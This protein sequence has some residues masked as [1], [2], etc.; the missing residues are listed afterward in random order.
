MGSTLL[1]DWL[2][3][4]TNDVPERDRFDVWRDAFGSVHDVFVD[5][6]SR[7][8]FRA[9]C[10]CLAVRETVFGVY[11]APA[12]R[13][14]RAPEHLA[15][16]DIDHLAVRIA[17]GGDIRGTQRGTEYH[18]T[19]G[20]I[21][22]G[23]LAYGYEEAHSAGG[24]AAAFLPRSSLPRFVDEG[25]PRMVHGVRGALLRDILLSFANS[26]S[27]AT[28]DDLLLFEDVL[29]RV[30]E[31]ILLDKEGALATDDLRLKRIDDILRSEMGSPRLNAASICERAGLSR[32]TLYR[33]FKD[34]GG[35][36]AYLAG[37]RLDAIRRDLQAPALSTYPISRIAENRG[38]HNVSAFNRAFQRRFGCTPTDVR[39]GSGRRQASAFARPA[40]ADDPSGSFLQL[41]R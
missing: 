34:R 22:I 24:W 11:H 38:M 32:T 39:H 19:P 30:L 36:E 1:E 28:H 17:L 16:H 6:G 9:S 14:V 12:R 7:L 13:V 31:S 40:K 5:P 26:S 25:K 20:A 8:D 10:R 29:R 37:L 4:D 33:L 41:L 15:R 35:V 3:I 21:A 18:L 2:V 27:Q 23:T